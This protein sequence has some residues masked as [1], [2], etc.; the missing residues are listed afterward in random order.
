[1]L[2]WLGDVGG[3]FDALSLIGKI[4]LGPLSAFALKSELLTSV[5][6]KVGDISDHEGSSD[7]ANRIS[8][9]W[10]SPTKISQLNFFYAL[11]RCFFCRTKQDKY[12][13]MLGKSEV[14]IE[15]ELDL[16]KFMER[17]RLQSLALIA[18]L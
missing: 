13:R 16:I 4:L 2:E 5:F 17:Q 11:L 1:M 9:P 3:L 10:K 6:K 8:M 15:S 14:A 12:A 18:L 7:T